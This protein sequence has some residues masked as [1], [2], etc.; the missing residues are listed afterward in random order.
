MNTTTLEVI[1]QAMEN[2]QNNMKSPNKWTPVT[3]QR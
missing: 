3:E 1:S 2:H